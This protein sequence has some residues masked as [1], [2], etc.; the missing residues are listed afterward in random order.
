METSSMKLTHA[1]LKEKL[2]AE[3]VGLGDESVS[4]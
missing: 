1:R 4:L 3:T 2:L